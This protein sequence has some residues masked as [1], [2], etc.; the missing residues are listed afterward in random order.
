MISLNL[1]RESALVFK[2]IYICNVPHYFSHGK[3]S[4]DS[5]WQQEDIRWPYLC[6]SLTYTIWRLLY[7]WN[8]LSFTLF[9]NTCSFLK[10]SSL[11]SP[12][13][14]SELFLNQ[15]FH[16]FLFFHASALLPSGS[17]NP[18][19]LQTGSMR[20]R[21]Q[22]SVVYFPFISSHPYILFHCFPPP[23]SYS[24][25]FSVFHIERHLILNF[26]HVSCRA[27]CLAAPVPLHYTPPF[28]LSPPLHL[29]CCPIWCCLSSC[30]YLCPMCSYH[31]AAAT[32]ICEAA[33][34]SALLMMSPHALS[35]LFVWC[36]CRAVHSCRC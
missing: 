26:S 11:F 33:L 17:T 12:F 27:S 24:L 2:L 3:M 35:T 18:W 34:V 23:P 30:H 8:C 6:G 31:L 19:P 13:L 7:S 21:G 20:V 36:Q 28:L 32:S 1:A 25:L 5:Y 15:L 14:T 22:T 9:S 10:G 29:S 4:A 16:A